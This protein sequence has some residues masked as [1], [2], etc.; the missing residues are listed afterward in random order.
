MSLEISRRSF[1]TLAIAGLLTPAIA[2]ARVRIRPATVMVVASLHKGH[3]T[4]PNYTYDDLNKIIKDFKADWV[5]VEI[6]PEDMNA[7]PAYVQSWYPQEMWNLKAAYGDKAFGF[8][9]FGDDLNGQPIPADW[10]TSS[11]IKT[12]ESQADSAPE[13]QTPDRQ[14]LSVK[15]DTLRAQQD[16]LL[17]KTNPRGLN[18]GR[19]DA[20][21]VQY[22]DTLKQY[23]DGTKFADVSTFYT[24]RDAHITANI[25]A[26]IK[27]HSGDR[28]AIVT[29]ADHHG[30]V[31][32]YIREKMP[33]VKLRRV[34]QR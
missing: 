16:A 15:L 12:L 8:D 9:W 23:F 10:R 24:A 32:R 25:A 22:Y 34:T 29:G 18:D 6:R 28:I 19:Y 7:D 4:D 33:D 13:L 1:A 20:L 3:L 31:T 27:A 30:P 17:A 26:F 2:F 14:A 11:A 5:G 21:C